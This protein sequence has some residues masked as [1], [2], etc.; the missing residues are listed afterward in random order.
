MRSI[1]FEKKNWLMHTMQKFHLVQSD[2]QH[3]FSLRGKR[4]VCDTDSRNS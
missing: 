4:R 3:S 1:D 2:V